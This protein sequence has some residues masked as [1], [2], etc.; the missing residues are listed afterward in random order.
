[1]VQLKR[2]SQ[3]KHAIGLESDTGIEVLIHIGIDTVKLNGEG[4]ESLVDVNEPVTQGQPLMKI[5]LA[6]LK[7]HAPVSL[8]Q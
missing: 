4:F 5:N 8:H 7:E 6:Y 3:Q 1:M 2:F